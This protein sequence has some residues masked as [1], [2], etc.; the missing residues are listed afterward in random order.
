MCRCSTYK[1]I[2]ASKNERQAF[3]LANLPSF[4]L[5]KLF[6]VSDFE[7]DGMFTGYCYSK[8]IIDNQ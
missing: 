6:L 3:N 8:S 1:D 4:P 2:M 5:D 7:W